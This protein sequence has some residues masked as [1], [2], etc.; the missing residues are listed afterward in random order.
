MIKIKDLSVSFSGIQ[1]F[2]EVGFAIEHGDKIGFIGRS[3]SVFF[4]IFIIKP[5]QK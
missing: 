5:G 1:I 2:D 4:R 3:G